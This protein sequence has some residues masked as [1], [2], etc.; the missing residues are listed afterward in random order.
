MVREN[1]LENPIPI[2]PLDLRFPIVRVVRSFFREYQKSE[3]RSR[4]SYDFTIARFF[5]YFRVQANNGNQAFYAEHA[6]FT[7]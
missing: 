2:I 1:P 4:L 7:F 3:K 5:F 6:D